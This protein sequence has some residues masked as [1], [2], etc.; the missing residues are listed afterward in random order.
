MS[1]KIRITSLV[2]VLVHN[3]NSCSNVEFEI[4]DIYFQNED[5]YIIRG[6]D[7]Y[8]STSISFRT[9]PPPPPSSF[10]RMLSYWWYNL[11]IY[12]RIHSVWNQRKTSNYEFHNY[13]QLPICLMI[14]IWNNQNVCLMLAIKLKWETQI[15]VRY[16]T[17]K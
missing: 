15:N 5:A 16:A 14:W 11:R 2:F 12:P 9:N 10:S 13:I 17:N 4:T 3:I 8:L 1:P 6:Y 7:H